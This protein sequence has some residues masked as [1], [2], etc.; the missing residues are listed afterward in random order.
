MAS[1]RT[2]KG[3]SRQLFSTLTNIITRLRAPAP[4]ERR[5]LFPAVHWAGT[6][7]TLHPVTVFFLVAITS[8]ILLF[9]PASLLHLA[10]ICYRGPNGWE[11]VGILYKS[12]WSIAYPFVLPL[13]FALAANVCR[14]I[15]HDYMKLVQDGTVQPAGKV[16]GA[17]SAAFL[18]FIGARQRLKGRVIFIRSLAL[19]LSA[20]LVDQF[21]NF[22]AYSSVFWHV[23]VRRNQHLSDWLST[24]CPGKPPYS[25]GIFSGWYNTGCWD[26][27]DWMHAWTL[28]GPNQGRILSNFLFYILAISVEGVVIFLACYFV[29]SFWTVTQSLS[30]TITNPR[31]PFRFVPFIRDPA[32]CLGL[33]PI[34]RQFSTFLL[35]TVIFQCGAFAHRFQVLLHGLKNDPAN[36]EYN[37]ITVVGYLSQIYKQISLLPNPESEAEAT[38]KNQK[39][40]FDAKTLWTLAGFKDTN[41]GLQVGIALSTVPL[42]VVCWWPL[43]KL[44]RFLMRCKRKL[45]RSYRI[46]EQNARQQRNYDEAEYTAADMEKLTQSTVWPNGFKVGWGFLFLLVSLFLSTIAPPLVVPLLAS[47]LT[48][49]VVEKL[50]AASE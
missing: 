23:Y 3:L 15:R 24:A 36:T 42:L 22:I 41:D 20:V 31:T 34:G 6:L 11:N 44:R 18:R 47:G 10:S 25:V 45:I 16:S 29:L 46:I 39:E 26:D 50:A 4:R 28:L 32:A 48:I 30:V 19:T 7:L 40:S 1:T 43:L 33:R 2:R 17:P 12:N 5:F 9:L 14:C 27:Q 13:I 8:S 38:N 21:H 35:L 37:N 49:K